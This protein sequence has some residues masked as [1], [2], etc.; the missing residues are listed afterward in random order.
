MR[1][2]GT[3]TVS[4]RSALARA[5]FFAGVSAADLERFER[6]CNWRTVEDGATVLDYDDASSDVYFIIAGEVRILIRTSAGREVI[7]ADMRAGEFFG[8]LAAIDGAPRSA[9]VT[10]LTRCELVIVPAPV[11]G[12]ML[13]ALPALARALMRL[14]VGRVRALNARLT[15]HSVLDVRHRLYSELLRLSAVRGGGK[16]ERSISPPPFHHVLAARVGCR[17]EQVS[18]EL[19]A[20]AQEGITEKTRGALVIR[21]P[22][23]LRARIETALADG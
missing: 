17:R 11:F 19:S 13:E 20:L 14:L 10:A 8:E 4:T 7:L 23:T 12:D 21:S 6:R 9:N 2:G 15:E 5:P 22:E 1:Q 16:G 18:R 3:M